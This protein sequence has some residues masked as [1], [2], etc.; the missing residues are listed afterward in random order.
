M[1][2]VWNRS[3]GCLAIFIFNI[4]GAVN[5][6]GLHLPFPI[7]EDNVE[8]LMTEVL[9]LMN[10]IFYWSLQGKQ[11]D[12]WSYERINF[13]LPIQISQILP[14]SFSIGE[15]FHF[16][17]LKSFYR[18]IDN[19]KIKKVKFF[20]PGSLQYNA[21]VCVALHLKEEVRK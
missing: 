12:Y 16:S 3:R 6:G 17:Q 7:K 9:R 15:W 18:L 2:C 4:N 19:E 21:L 20:S 14:W 13:H 8:V 5:Y 10:E 11:M 1:F